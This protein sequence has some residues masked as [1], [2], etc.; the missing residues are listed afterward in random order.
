[1]IKLA[2]NKSFIKQMAHSNEPLQVEETIETVGNFMLNFIPKV[3]V[4]K[5]LEEYWCIVALNEEGLFSSKDSSKL[6]SFS[7]NI[8]SYVDPNKLKLYQ[9]FIGLGYREFR[10]QSLS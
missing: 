5:E 4:R 1:L 7:N 9:L 8:S 3:D 2:I 6:C 10:L